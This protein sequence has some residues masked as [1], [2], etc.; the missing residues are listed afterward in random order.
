MT[1]NVDISNLLSSSEWDQEKQ[2]FLFPLM[3]TCLA[4][5]IAYMMMRRI[6]VIDCTIIKN[7]HLFLRTECGARV[8]WSIFR[9][10][11]RRKQSSNHAAQD[12]ILHRSLSSI[13]RFALRSQTTQNPSIISFFVAL[14][15]K[16]GTKEMS[17]K[18]FGK[19]IQE[20][21]V[22][23]HERFR[24]RICS[25]DDRYFEVSLDDSFSTLRDTACYFSLT[26]STLS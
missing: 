21:V 9:M 2:R 3:F 17:Q 15:N 1:G 19:L 7:P 24:S 4:I 23:T 20:R 6:K 5:G 14:S 25:N 10:S 13:G 8:W 18:D 16:K 12:T 26:F 22:T 11:R